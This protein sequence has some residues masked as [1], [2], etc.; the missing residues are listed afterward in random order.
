[1]NERE[2]NEIVGDVIAEIERRKREE[3]KTRSMVSCIWADFDDRM[4][5]LA[6]GKYSPPAEKEKIKKGISALLA[7][8]YRVDYIVR[9]PEERETE[10][11]RFVDKVL[12]AIEEQ[13]GTGVRVDE[14]F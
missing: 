14:I 10:I 6:E 2:K 8:A 4:E 13:R 5:R 11:R 7:V 3:K 12:S 9:L 1:M